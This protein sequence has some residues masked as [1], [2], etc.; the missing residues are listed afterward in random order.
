MPG[1]PAINLTYEIN[2]G[3]CWLHRLTWILCNQP[4][5][6]THAINPWNQQRQLLISWVNLDCSKRNPQKS[7]QWNQVAF[8]VGIQHFLGLIS[9]DISVC[10]QPKESTAPGLD[11][12]TVEFNMPAIKVAFKV[13]STL[14]A[15]SLNSRI[16]QSSPDSVDSLGWFGSRLCLR[17]STYGYPPPPR[18][19]F[20]RHM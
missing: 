4:M 8:N 9:L 3:H 6:S 19:W 2:N 11:C 1:H 5:Q 7:T 17:N 10:N 18:C 13:G 12:T 16:W 15:D 14:N 20:L